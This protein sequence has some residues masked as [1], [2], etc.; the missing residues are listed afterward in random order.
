MT[1]ESKNA[2][3]VP[4][5]VLLSSAMAPG[6]AGGVG[7][8]ITGSIPRRLDSHDI[9][10]LRATL[11]RGAAIEIRCASAQAW[12]AMRGPLFRQIGLVA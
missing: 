2:T 6:G 11:A 9:A 4:Y 1:T 12:R 8:R 7:S 3:A 10:S 5:V